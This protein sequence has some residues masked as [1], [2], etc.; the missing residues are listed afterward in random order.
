M[1]LIERI[2]LSPGAKRSECD[3]IVVGALIQILAVSQQQTTAALG[4]AFVPDAFRRSLFFKVGC[5][6]TQ[7][8]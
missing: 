1:S 6:G 5:G 4:E 3:V 8:S 2:D 7:P